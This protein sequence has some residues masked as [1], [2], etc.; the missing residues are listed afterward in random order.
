MTGVGDCFS[1]SLPEKNSPS[2]VATAARDDA[3]SVNAYCKTKRRV[4]VFAGI[5]DDTYERKMIAFRLNSI[6]R[7]L[8][9]APSLNKQARDRHYIYQEVFCNSFRHPRW[10][11]S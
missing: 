11:N 8:V 10:S 2:I 5:A 4:E 7:Q 9:T 3:L 1:E 6:F